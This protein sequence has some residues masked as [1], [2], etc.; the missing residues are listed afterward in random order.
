MDRDRWFY[1]ADIIATIGY[2]SNIPK[3]DN[4]DASTSSFRGAIGDAE[5]CEWLDTRTKLSE[6]CC[7]VWNGRGNQFRLSNAKSGADLDLRKINSIDGK[8]CN[9]LL[10][11]LSKL[12][13]D[14]RVSEN[15]R[16]LIVFKTIIDM[17]SDIYQ[18]T[19]H[20]IVETLT[21][22]LKS[23]TP[24]SWSHPVVHFSTY[25]L[26]SWRP[27][28]GADATELFIGT[29]SKILDTVVSS[30]LLHSSRD[31]FDYFR[32]EIYLSALL[33]RCKCVWL[34]SNSEDRLTKLLS[35]IC[36]DKDVE[37]QILY[38]LLNFTASLLK[39]STASSFRVRPET[40][41][42]L[43][44]FLEGVVT[45][46]FVLQMPGEICDSVIEILSSMQHLVD[47]NWLET[48]AIGAHSAAISL[49]KP[50]KN[51]FIVQIALL[52]FTTK[53][54][55]AQLMAGEHRDE[56]R[57]TEETTDTFSSIQDEKNQVSRRDA[58]LQAFLLHTDFC[59]LHCAS[60]CD[61]KSVDSEAESTMGHSASE[62]AKKQSID[63]LV[64]W[65]QTK[66]N[67]EDILRSISSREFL[68]C[69]SAS[70]S[71]LNSTT[72]GFPSMRWSS[73]ALEIFRF[74]KGPQP[75]FNFLDEN[76]IVKQATQILG[77]F[78]NGKY[79]E[80]FNFLFCSPSI[81]F[82]WLI[83]EFFFPVFSL[84]DILL[85]VQEEVNAFQRKL[86]S[87]IICHPSSI[88]AVALLVSIVKVAAVDSHS[89]VPSPPKWNI[90]IIFPAAA[91]FGRYKEIADEV[92]T[93]LCI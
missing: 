79:A 14:Q 7:G 57:R 61:Y 15:P 75:Y 17:Q 30:I 58:I 59:I 11:A 88:V 40:A 39:C 71:G 27:S 10:E 80:L 34:L 32:S 54:I 87:E 69:L 52:G 33:L 51:S 44:R 76:S 9:C 16:Y 4:N 19:I 73:I 93:F 38:S 72:R 8:F 68:N 41:Y 43:V 24:H 37:D 53:S 6:F 1:F 29:Y 56:G 45:I 31:V 85:L 26:L 49:E 50:C 22:W 5:S 23:G 13:V 21:A 48:L 83:S 62:R 47:F 78:E 46:P 67:N 90:G 42:I 3:S 12:I 25:I 60:E 65:M 74:T 82:K 35:I 18:S 64:P 2:M 28:S 89:F 55:I 36:M 86:P 77:S 92:R 91:A 20:S 70:T 81:F 66:C 63:M 84:E